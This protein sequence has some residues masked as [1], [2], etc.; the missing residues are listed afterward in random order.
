MESYQYMSPIQITTSGK[1]PFTIGQLRHL[2][3]FRHK[4]GLST[5]VRKIGKRLMIRVDIFDD[6]IEKQKEGKNG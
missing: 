1:Y 3:L 4:N 2:L 6:W 5:A